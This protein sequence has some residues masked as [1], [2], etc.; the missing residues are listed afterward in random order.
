MNVWTRTWCCVLASALLALG[1]G[2]DDEETAEGTDA[3]SVQL[4]RVRHPGGGTLE[5]GSSSELLLGCDTSQ[6]VLVEVA[7][8]PSEW[9][10]RPSGACSSTH[11]G[12]V[13]LY[14]DDVQVAQAAARVL[15]LSVPEAGEHTL[16]VELRAAN[17]AV[18]E[19]KD[20]GVLSSAATVNFVPNTSCSEPDAG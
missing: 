16:R 13:V 8:E 2:D 20:A 10:L 6:P 14:L 3:E 17:G 9:N 5:V 15:Q 12:Y 18:L 19:S 1:C 4:V 7:I 11:C